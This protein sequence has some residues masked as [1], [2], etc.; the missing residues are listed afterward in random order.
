LAF[1]VTGRRAGEGGK[2]PLIK[3]ATGTVVGGKVVVEGEAL[4]E[5]STVTV[6]L[7]EDDEAFDLTPEEEAE[8]LESIAAIERGEFVSGEQLLQRL[9]QIG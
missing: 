6:V 3:V 7:R 5:G 4:A 8:L 2:I 9:R 1:G